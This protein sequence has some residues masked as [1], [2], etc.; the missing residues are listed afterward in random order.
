MKILSA[1]Q[2]RQADAY[3]IEHEPIAS[4][5]LMERAS[6]AFVDYFTRLFGTKNKILICCGTGNNG[7][8][9]L[10]IARLLSS[11][12]Y[13]VA[14][15]VVRPNKEA[16]G[17]A[18][19]EINY[20]LLPGIIPLTEINDNTQVPEKFN[21]DIIIDAIFG[22]G[23][24]RPVEGLYAFVIR[25]IN[26]SQAE[27]VS[28]DIASGLFCDTI[29]AEGPIVTPHMTISFQLPKLAFLLPENDPFVGEW[30]V[31][32]IGLSSDFIAD[33]KSKS[34][35]VSSSDIKKMLRRRE[36]YSHKGTFGRALLIGGS[37][38]KIGA[39]VLSS[40]ACLRS[41]A[42]L[43]ITH[44]PQCGYEVLQTAVPECMVTTDASF[45]YISE[46]PTIQNYQ[47]I[48]I[49]PGLGV[50]EMSLKALR[51]LLKDVKNP[52]VIDA[53]AINLIAQND[54]LIDLLP[55]NT[56][57]TPHPKEFERLAGPWEND[58]ERLDLQREF[59]K[60]H[61]VLIV[62]KGAHTSVSTP[63]GRVYFNSTGN[64]GMATAGSGDVLTGILTGLLSRGYSARKAAILGVYMHG[65][66]GDLAAEKLG[67]ESLIAS[68]IIDYLPHAFTSVSAE[69]YLIKK[70]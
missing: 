2:I 16:P 64:P 55:A 67:E 30:K 18:D 62:L 52:M 69:K 29:A 59:S 57:L 61:E 3:T 54:D 58:L 65:L 45:E 36:K 24:S 21:T 63:E 7:G 26:Q 41:G 34:H 23:L 20:R 31:V 60:K 35:Y 15:L 68:D 44:V 43:L 1:P 27:V 33:Q 19:F 38:G 17:S 40:R 70:K 66:A 51:E 5:D 11:M 10:A 28:V 56:I 53:D 14:V 39:I 22:S 50:Q 25:A 47:A 42:G 46:L 13:E 49:G 4:I 8:D 48:G 32:D 12:N 37:Y 9:G 6:N